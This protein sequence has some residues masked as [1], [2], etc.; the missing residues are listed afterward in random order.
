MA[1]EGGRREEAGV[2][3]P[4]G[5]VGGQ[6][7]RKGEVAEHRHPRPSWR[8]RK[9]V[10]VLGTE[11]ELLVMVGEFRKSLAWGGDLKFK[12]RKLRGPIDRI[13]LLECN[14]QQPSSLRQEAAQI[15]WS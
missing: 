15:L 12:L 2:H 8:E 9:M 5:E 11:T 6:A 13:N 3:A 7:D 1:A 4:L 10:Q 14:S